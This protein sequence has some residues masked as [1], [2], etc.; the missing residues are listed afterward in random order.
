MKNFFK[1]I[2]AICVC[3]ICLCLG[4][5]AASNNPTIQAVLSQ[6]IRVKVDGEYKDMYDINGNQVY[7]I[8]YNGST[9]VPVRAVSTLLGVPVDWDNDTRTVILGEAK[10]AELPLYKAE[11][12]ANST[13]AT[14]WLHHG[15]ENQGIAWG[16]KDADG[17][18]PYIMRGEEA[19][20]LQW[21]NWN[22]SQSDSPEWRIN[23]DTKEYNTIKFNLG[24][25]SNTTFTIYN[26]NGE[27]IQTWNLNANDI[28]ENIE[29]DI[30]GAGAISF[31]GNAKAMLG[32]GLVF[33]VNPIL[34]NK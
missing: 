32:S 25:T 23:F 3:S 11:A 13:I 22:Y 28:I 5:F 26:G 7:P 16:N 21:S 20:V 8:A 34:F 9:Y 15:G 17:N 30:T 19:G 27:V 29:V 33:V 4:A 12:N 10:V 2:I 14:K 1:P 24:C 18:W 6:D 31:G